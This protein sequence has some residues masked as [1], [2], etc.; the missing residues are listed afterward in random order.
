MIKIILIEDELHA[1]D[2]F[3]K[4][5][6]K[7]FYNRVKICAVSKTVREG[8]ELIKK[9]APDVVFLDVELKSES[10]LQIFDYLTDINFKVVFTTAHK[11]YAIEAIKAGRTRVFDYLLKPLSFIELGETIQKLEEDNSEFLKHQKLYTLLEG[12]THKNNAYDKI[13]F[14]TFKGVDIEDPSNIMY[15]ESLEN[16]TRLITIHGKVILVSKPMKYIEDAVPSDLFF[17][18]HKS[19]LINL[20]FVQNFNKKEG[21]SVQMV[22]GKVFDVSIRNKSVLYKRLIGENK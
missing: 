10:G 8:V 20:N 16:Y 11:N 21:S 5:C 3:Q 4:Y 2:L 7:Y 13:A 6:Q 19:S 14:P 9:Y 12:L 1:Q 22:N 18:I 17:R 15:C